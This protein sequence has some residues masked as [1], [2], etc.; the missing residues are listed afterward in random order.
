MEKRAGCEMIEEMEK[1]NIFRIKIYLDVFDKDIIFT[2]WDSAKD[3]LINTYLRTLEA[4][5]KNTVA[6][7][8]PKDEETTTVFLV[9]NTTIRE[10]MFKWNKKTISSFFNTFF[11]G[12]IE[13]LEEVIYT[14]E[15]TPIKKE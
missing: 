5:N 15:L 6:P 14:N 11:N 3:F 1:I 4:I 9:I 13:I 8:L 12:E 2:S 10:S 7:W